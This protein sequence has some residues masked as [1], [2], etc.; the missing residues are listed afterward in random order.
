MK[1]R[2]PISPTTPAF[3]PSWPP[4][5]YG[6]MITIVLKGQITADDLAA[7]METP[8]DGLG[9][10]IQ[11]LIDKEF[12]KA[13]VQLVDGDEQVFYSAT[14]EGREAFFEQVELLRQAITGKE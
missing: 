3:V 5:E 1:E 14:A 7:S 6:L 10:R 4:A 8:S 13:S 11:P 9:G 2:E 12:V